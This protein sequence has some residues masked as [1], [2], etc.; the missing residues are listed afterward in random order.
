M[1]PPLNASD[2]GLA[3]S[4]AEGHVHE[5]LAATL[6]SHNLSQSRNGPYYETSPYGREYNGQV[7]HESVIENPTP[8]LP[9]ANLRADRKT[10]HYLKLEGAIH[11]WP[12]TY[13]EPSSIHTFTTSTLTFPVTNAKDFFDKFV[14]NGVQNISLLLL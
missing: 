1:G 14:G 6:P 7:S 12:W 8:F 2:P 9:R 5:T 3:S 13:A 11:C 4:H 10:L